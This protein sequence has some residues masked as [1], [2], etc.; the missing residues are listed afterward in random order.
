MSKEPNLENKDKAL[1]IGVVSG[2]N[3]TMDLLIQECKKY[4]SKSENCVGG[5]LHIVLDDENI[6]DGH[7]EWCKNYAK[8]KGDNEGVALAEL[9]LKAT[10]EQR[11]KLVS[12]YSSYCH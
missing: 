3:I 10:M 9:L 4:Y 11:E 5:S 6:E 2:S 8:E 1:H 12:N 7:I